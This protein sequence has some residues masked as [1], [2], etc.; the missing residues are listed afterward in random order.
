MDIIPIWKSTYYSTTGATAVEF[1]VLRD[2]EFEIFHGYAQPAPNGDIKVYLNDI[3][4][5][6]L[7]SKLPFTALDSTGD[8]VAAQEGYQEFTLKIYNEMSGNWDT[9]Y[10]WAFVNDTSYAPHNATGAYSEP[11]NGHCAPGQI[12][13]YTYLNAY[14]ATYTVCYEIN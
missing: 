12:L 4:A 9:G 7:N 2:N 10:N 11:I 8:T 13:P 1:K 6:Y 3:C 14:N 5:S